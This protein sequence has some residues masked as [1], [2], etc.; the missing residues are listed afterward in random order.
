[1]KA[2]ALYYSNS[3][4]LRTDLETKLR[5]TTVLPA[6]EQTKKSAGLCAISLTD[7]TPRRTVGL[8]WRRDCYR[9]DA[10]NAFMEYAHAVVGDYASQGR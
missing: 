7:P 10:T 8:L 9:C 1:M 5:R 3:P 2:I 6:L 4:L